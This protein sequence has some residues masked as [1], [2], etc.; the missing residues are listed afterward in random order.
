MTRRVDFTAYDLPSMAV[1]CPSCGARVGAYCRRPSGHAGPMV[2]L[3]VER[4]AEADRV[5]EAQG[6]GWISRTPEGG[7]VL[8]PLDADRRTIPAALAKAIAEVEAEAPAPRRAASSLAA[9]PPAPRQGAL[10]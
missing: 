2:R 10:F 8:V 4:G 3:H 9:A 7:W 1:A 5:H 6:G